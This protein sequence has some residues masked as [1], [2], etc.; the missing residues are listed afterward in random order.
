L[1]YYYYIII[2]YHAASIG[3]AWGISPLPWSKIFGSASNWIEIE[4]EIDEIELAIE[5]EMAI[6]LIEVIE[7][8]LAISLI[9]IIEIELLIEIDREIIEIDREII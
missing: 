3:P 7:V 4:M 6:S 1:D 2:Y 8:E 5:S 9:E